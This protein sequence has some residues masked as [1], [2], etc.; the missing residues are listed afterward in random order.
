MRVRVISAAAAAL[1]TLLLAAA[2]PFG[3]SA[4]ESGSGDLGPLDQK[5]SPILLAEMRNVAKESLKQTPHF[6]HVP[7][8]AIE[9]KEA[10]PSAQPLVLYIGAD[11]C[12]FCAG[13]RWPLVLTLM[14]FGE[15]S[16]LRYTRSAS[17]DVFPNTATFSFSDASYKSDYIRLEAVEIQ[18]RDGKA[19]EKPTAAQRA[20]F[21]RYNDRGSIPFLYL[22]GRYV[23]V[24]APFT[25]GVFK[26]LDWQQI[27]AQLGQGG[28]AAWQDVMSETDLL[29]AALCRLTK[30]A[31]AEVCK[32]PAVAAATTHLP[33]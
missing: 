11:Y 7:L 15:L 12:P 28:N 4:Q 27:A 16:D 30:G 20:T 6:G 18:D 17:R 13:L 19:L 3:A 8:K 14:R 9:D 23:E 26:G 25:P 24:G 32:A 22:G 31:P 10:A 33:K 1:S 21:T 2:L 29:S 5:V